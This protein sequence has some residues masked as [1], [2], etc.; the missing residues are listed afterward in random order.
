MFVF[1]L[2]TSHDIPVAFIILQWSPLRHLSIYH[3]VDYAVSHFKTAIILKVYFEAAVHKCI[4]IDI[5]NRGGIVKHNVMFTFYLMFSKVLYYY[6]FEN[7]VHKNKMILL[8]NLKK[9]AYFTM[10]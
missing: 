6:L 3:S 1:S 9:I 5:E 8:Y 10:N 7:T 4:L 2:D